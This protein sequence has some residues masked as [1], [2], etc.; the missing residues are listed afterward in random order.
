[1]IAINPQWKDLSDSLD[2]GNPCSPTS[3][4]M[5]NSQVFSVAS[6]SDTENSKKA[7]T[8]STLRSSITSKYL[9]A[10]LMMDSETNAVAH[11]ALNSSTCKSNIVYTK[12]G[13]SMRNKRKSLQIVGSSVGYLSGFFK[14]PG[15]SK[16][17][18]HDFD[19][20]DP[21]SS[22]C[23]FHDSTPCQRSIVRGT[24]NRK[25]KAVMN[26]MNVH[27]KFSDDTNTYNRDI[28][29]LTEDLTKKLPN[30]VKSLRRVRFNI[31]SDDRGT[32]DSSPY[33]EDADPSS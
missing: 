21:V 27:P 31:P 12:N 17:S 7:W 2:Q 8:L 19:A 18:S 14:R 13:N 24:T 4:S 9:W 11:T 28:Q 33:P 22:M 26:P 29:N 5:R 3:G 10:M 15:I 6:A 23:S 1:M 16:L 30:N 25:S 20:F 32:E